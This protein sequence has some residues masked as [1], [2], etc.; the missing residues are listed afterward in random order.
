MFKKIRNIKK[1]AIIGGTVF[2]VFIIGVSTF[3]IV[4]NI[5]MNKK[6]DDIYNMLNKETIVDYNYGN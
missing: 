3:L 1:M 4:S 6:I 5:K 2:L